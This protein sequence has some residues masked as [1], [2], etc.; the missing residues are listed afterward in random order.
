MLEESIEVMA[1][2]KYILRKKNFT[3][4]ILFA[5]VGSNNVNA[6]KV[7]EDCRPTAPLKILYQQRIVAEHINATISQVDRWEANVMNELQKI[8]SV[9]DT[10]LQ[11]LQPSQYKGKNTEL[12]IEFKVQHNQI[13]R[14]WKIYKSNLSTMQEHWLEM[15]NW[16]KEVQS[17]NV[18]TMNLVSTMEKFTDSLITTNVTK[19]QLFQMSRQVSILQRMSIFFEKLKSNIDYKEASNILQY[20]GEDAKLAANAFEKFISQYNA[21]EITLNEN[22]KKRL[23]ANLDAFKKLYE[24]LGLILNKSPVIFQILNAKDGSQELYYDL[25]QSI[26]S[27]IVAYLNIKQ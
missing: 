23:L 1:I 14:S 10:S 19:E 11:E 6:E 13:E 4:L 16:R 25:K 12:P 8:Q 3:V 26:D 15:V 2:V 24:K 22:M 5:I 27:T 17:A 7:I 18:L 9:F 21:E 20:L